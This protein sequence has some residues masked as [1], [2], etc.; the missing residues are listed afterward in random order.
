MS[1]YIQFFIRSED[2]FMPISVYSRNN[3]IYQYFDE[4]APWGKI[5]PVTRELLRKVRDNIN[6]D[7]AAIQKKYDQAKEMKEWIA[8]LNNSLEEKMEYI[9]NIEE[10]LGEYCEEI[11]RLIYTK[12]YLTF[13]DDVIGSVEYE[14]HIDYKN[15]LYVGIEVG[16]PTV[17]DI[18]R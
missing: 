2:A 9:E 15:Y 11:D 1:A 4:Y 18:V 16:N 13:L 10:A 6:E 17:D 7:L 14:G 5:K 12:Y 8:T 3:T